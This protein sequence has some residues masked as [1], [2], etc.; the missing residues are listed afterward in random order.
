MSDPNEAEGVDGDDG[1]E[2]K[3]GVETDEDVETLREG[4]LGK[5]N[6]LGFKRGRF[7]ALTRLE[8]NKGAGD[9]EPEDVLD[10]GNDGKGSDPEAEGV[11]G[12]GDRQAEDEVDADV[13]N[14]GN[15]RD[16]NGTSMV[17]SFSRKS[18]ST[19]LMS[20]LPLFAFIFFKYVC[21][22]L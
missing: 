9:R 4:V 14:V 11:A 7:S 16:S 6:S 19:I 20:F 21:E 2:F 5:D 18:P 15:G 10:V 3:G 8:S 13:A 1:K 17:T 12:A 22:R